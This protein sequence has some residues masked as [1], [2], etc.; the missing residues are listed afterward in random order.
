MESIVALLLILQLGS[1]SYS[2]RETA[3]FRLASSTAPAPWLCWGAG[4]SDPEIATRC[5]KLLLPIKQ[6]KAAVYLASF[7]PVGWDVV[8]WLDA[9][10]LGWTAGKYDRWDVLEGCLHRARAEIPF[11]LQ[12]RPWW[13]EYRLATEYFLRGALEEKLLTDAELRALLE[14]M[15]EREIHWIAKGGYPP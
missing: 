5:V 11:K 4:H 1:S 12:G 15:G 10:P 7:K 9:L 3:Y 6:R 14:I 8:P 2:E 13:P